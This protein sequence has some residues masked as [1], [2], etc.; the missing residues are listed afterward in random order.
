[1][2]KEGFGRGAA[3][4]IGKGRGSGTACD[5]WKEGMA[6]SSSAAYEGRATPRRLAERL[7]GCGCPP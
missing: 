6:R 1:L 7:R 5:G 3:M 2:K 4:D